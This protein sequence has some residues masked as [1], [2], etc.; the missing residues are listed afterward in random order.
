MS[1]S[2]MVVPGGSAGASHIDGEKLVPLALQTLGFILVVKSVV[3]LRSDTHEDTMEE[4]GKPAPPR[5]PKL[6][7]SQP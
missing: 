3:L 5:R 4:Q 2:L 1:C 7:A 6:E